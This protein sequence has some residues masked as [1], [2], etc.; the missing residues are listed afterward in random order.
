MSPAYQE[1]TEVSDRDLN[2]SKVVNKRFSFGCKPRHRSSS[3][4]SGMLSNAC[5]KG[6]VVRITFRFAPPPVL[7]HAVVPRSCARDRAPYNC[8]KHS[9]E[10]AGQLLSRSARIYR[11]SHAHTGPVNR[12]CTS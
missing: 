9:P 1:A 6:L 2:G 10:T 4:E 12:A 11:R 7:L 8:K 5:A 3:V